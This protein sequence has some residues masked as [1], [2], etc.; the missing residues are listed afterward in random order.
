M[1]LVLALLLDA[2]FGEPKWIYDRVPHPA[3]LMGRLIGW[4][5]AKFNTGE[6]RQLKGLVTIAVLVLGAWILGVAL[7]ALP[8][9]NLIEILLT[10]ALLAQRSLV[11]HVRD[12]ALGLDAALEKGRQMVARI[13][14]RDTRDMDEAAIARGAIESG[15]ENLSDGVIAP[16]L[17]FLLAGL[18]GVLVYKVINTADSMI[19][20]RTERHLQF[21]WA[22]ARLDDVVNWVPAR[23]TSVL[24][25][26]SHWR[27]DVAKI[28]QSDATLHRSPNAGWPEAAMAG[29]LGISLSGPRSYDGQMRDEPYV[30]AEG[31]TPTSDDILSCVGVLWRSWALMAVLALIVAVVV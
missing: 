2:L 16:A 26:A 4:C 10:A 17:A 13:V 9:G 23:V 6:H 20:Y 28:V 8:L 31:R 5:D 25:L 30:H 15:A 21:G 1:S 11:D 19:G 3:V 18:P 14:G 29:V 22:A 7:A 12:V 27:W 24:I